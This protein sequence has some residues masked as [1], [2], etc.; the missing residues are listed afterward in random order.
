MNYRQL[1]LRYMAHIR[2]CEGIDFT[3]R[4]NDAWEGEVQFTPEEVSELKL[5]SSESTAESDI[6]AA[7]NL[8]PSNCAE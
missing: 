6:S 7:I 5:L 8:Q 1:L 2:S 4:L 3:D